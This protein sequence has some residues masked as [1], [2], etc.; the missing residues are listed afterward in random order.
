M[1]LNKIKVIIGK[2]IYNLKGLSLDDMSGEIMQS[3]YGLEEK[4]L[5]PE[6]SDKVDLKNYA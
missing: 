4:L 5:L 6:K 3:I 1:G 2:P